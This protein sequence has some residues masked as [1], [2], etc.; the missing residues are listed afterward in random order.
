MDTN[1]CGLRLEFCNDSCLK[2]AR[3]NYDYLKH[4]SFIANDKS[5]SISDQLTKNIFI[6]V[7]LYPWTIAKGG[8]KLLK[9]I[10]ELRA[11]I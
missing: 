5:E 6:F 4:I 1:T 10:L 2:A 8:I 7:S 11:G 3:E 9:Y